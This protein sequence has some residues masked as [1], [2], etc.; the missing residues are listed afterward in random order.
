MT[1]EGLRGNLLEADVNVDQW[2]HRLHFPVGNKSVV[3]GNSDEMDEAHV[4]DFVLVEVIE[5]VLP[6]SMVQMS[7]A[8]EHLAHDSL[9]ILVE[10]LRKIARLSDPF[11]GCVGN[12]TVDELRGR[13]G[14]RGTR[15]LARGKCDWVVN[16]AHNP[17]LNAIDELGS[18][19]LGCLIIHKPS[20]RRTKGKVRRDSRV[21]YIPEL[22]FRLS[23]P[24]R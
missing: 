4:E 16:L 17:P 15:H 5:W 9:A 6:V 19:D 3:L 2:L 23:W 11:L 14:Q 22:T 7:V 13:M 20:I 24:G 18:G 10:V 1:C 21:R 12:T 8:T